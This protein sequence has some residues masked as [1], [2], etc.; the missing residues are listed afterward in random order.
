MTDE[1]S[2]GSTAS[3][4][5]KPIRDFLEGGYEHREVSIGVLAT[6]IENENIGIFTWD[7]FGRFVKADKAAKE[8]ILNLLALIF[9]FENDFFD[10]HTHD[11]HPL[12]VASFQPDDPFSFFGWPSENIPDFNA[13]AEQEKAASRPRP[14]TQTPQEKGAVTRRK[15]SYLVIIGALCEKLGVDHKERGAAIKI[16]KYLEL[17][18]IKKDDGTLR[19][20]LDEV[21]EVVEL[22]REK[23]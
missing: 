13:L 5:F 4:S 12:D 15:N 21:Q 1:I 14:V 17:I 19:S 8:K 22:E 23:L 6:A 18:G 16:K 3:N 9:N 10:S 2:D 7:R 20:V 11:P